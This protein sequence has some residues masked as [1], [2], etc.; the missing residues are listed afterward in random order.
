MRRNS[1]SPRQIS[2]PTKFNGLGRL[3]LYCTACS[4]QCR[5]ENAF[6]QHTQSE[7][8]VRK[9]DA[10]GLNLGRISEQYSQQFLSDFLNLLRLTHGEKSVRANRFYQ[11]YIADR[12]HVHLKDTRW[13]SLTR[14]AEWLGREGHCRFEEKDDGVYIALID[15]SPEAERRAAALREKK[16]EEVADQRR[17]ERQ[18]EEQVKR[19]HARTKHHSSP[20]PTQTMSFG[21]QQDDGA[22]VAFRFSPNT[23]TPAS[24]AIQPKEAPNIFKAAGQ[25][26]KRPVEESGE[27]GLK[28]VIYKQPL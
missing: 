13:G 11:A 26:R 23:T 28:E 16:R 1:L 22:T 5:D 17:E 2:R 24:R 3:R 4:K 7:S 20:L 25:K 10:I 15:K 21:S 19:A 18:L 6:K 14:F 9:I 12:H 8:H 27:P